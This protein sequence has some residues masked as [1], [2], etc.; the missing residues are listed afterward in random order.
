MQSLQSTMCHPGSGKRGTASVPASNPAVRE[1]RFSP[2]DHCPWFT[3]GYFKTC[4][5]DRAVVAEILPLSLEEIFISEM[6]VE[7]YDVK[8]LLF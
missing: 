1:K 7:G 3:G 5:R 2:H 8:D 4:Q 6:E